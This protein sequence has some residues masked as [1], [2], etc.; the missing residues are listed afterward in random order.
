MSISIALQALSID[1]DKMKYCGYHRT[2]QPR[3]SGQFIHAYLHPAPFAGGV[4]AHAITLYV[5]GI[6][7]RT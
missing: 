4:I 5:V 7:T 3:A 6:L 2:I 1:V